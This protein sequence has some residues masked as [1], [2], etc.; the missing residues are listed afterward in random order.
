MQTKLQ[1]DKKRM[2]VTKAIPMNEVSLFMIHVVSC[3][4]YNRLL[5]RLDLTIWAEGGADGAGG[6]GAPNNQRFA[7]SSPAL[8]NPIEVS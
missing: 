3:L 4:Q 6:R 1:N 5:F 2:T 7:G 8:P